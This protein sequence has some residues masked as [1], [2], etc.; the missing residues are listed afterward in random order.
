VYKYLCKVKLLLVV[1]LAPYLR[2]FGCCHIHLQGEHTA[3]QSQLFKTCTHFTCLICIYYR[4]LSFSFLFLCV[5]ARRIILKTL[6][7]EC[8]LPHECHTRHDSLRIVTWHHVTHRLC[9]PLVRIYWCVFVPLQSNRSTSVAVVQLQVS[10]FNGTGV[11]V[12]ACAHA[13]RVQC[14][15]EAISV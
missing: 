8:K 1:C 2:C 11:C 14:R 7:T 9:Q 15:N 5:V 6:N 4:H 10:H 13:Y 3:S 12:R